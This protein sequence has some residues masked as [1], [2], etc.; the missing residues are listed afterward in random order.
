LQARARTLPL[1]GWGSLKSHQ[2]LKFQFMENSFFHMFEDLT[3]ASVLSEKASFIT[4]KHYITS[5]L[6]KV[7]E[8]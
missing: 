1:K 7:N 4:N 3:N 8:K 2:N 5:I 6:Q